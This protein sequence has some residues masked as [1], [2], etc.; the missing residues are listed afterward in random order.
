[1]LLFLLLCLYI[2]H[3]G[4]PCVETRVFSRI[5]EDTISNM[6]SIEFGKILSIFNYLYC[7]Q[8]NVKKQEHVLSKRANQYAYH[9]W[10]YCLESHTAKTK[11]L[12]NSS[13]SRLE[14][15]KTRNKLMCTQGFKNQKP[16]HNFFRAPKDM[17]VCTIVL[18]SNLSNLKYCLST[19]VWN[20]VQLWTFL[21]K[22]N[23]KIK[24]TVNN[25]NLSYRLFWTN[26]CHVGLYYSTNWPVYT[27]GFCY[28]FIKTFELF[29]PYRLRLKAR[30]RVC[31]QL[32]LILF[33]I[34]FEF[35]SRTGVITQWNQPYLHFCNTFCRLELMYLNEVFFIILNCIT[36]WNIEM[37]W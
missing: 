13:L 26:Y 22:S 37:F 35:L 21:N 4:N 28:L 29:Q 36:Y 15:W 19:H 20:C 1:M 14:L 18:L 17:F 25:D 3:C 12:I 5:I 34:P 31:I 16:L 8:E 9:S 6:Y 30:M 33:E 32:L 11:L 2:F 7:Y 10:A 24:L 27:N 23:S